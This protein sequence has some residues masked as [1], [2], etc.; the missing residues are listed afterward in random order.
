[1]ES[2]YTLTW[3]E[4][5]ELFTDSWPRP[6]YFSAA[7]VALVSIPLIAYGIIL[8]V[9]GMPDEHTI[10]FIFIG[11]PV[12]LVVAAFLSLASGNRKA[13]KQAM[14]EKRATYERWHAKEQ[15]FAFD[16]EKWILQSESGKLEV[17]WSALLAAVEWPSVLVLASEGAA[18]IVPKRAMNEGKLDLLRKMA[19]LEP[20]KKWPFKISVWD[21]QA[22]ET[23]R[24]W[25]RYWFRMAFGNVFGLVVLGWLFQIWHESNEKIG[26]VWGW[27]IAA[28]MLV[29]T[30]TAQIWY[31]PLKYWTSRREWRA[32]KELGLCGK[33]LYIG[34]AHVRVFNAW[35][36]LQSFDDFRRAF[37]VYKD[38]N[39]YHL[40]SK[41]YFFQEQREEI[42]RGLQENMKPK[43]T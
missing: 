16:E 38:K 30:L 17:P 35:K 33:G 3:E 4:Y 20:A 18:A 12:F 31:L 14:A 26:I 32:Q 43:S 24:I 42:R 9:F 10:N 37:V 23:V 41:H 40:L 27:V 15:S 7:V 1:M 28:F 19:I 22:T 5:A 8:A 11:G 36:Y 2:T 13:K 25:K 34:D 6:D 21:Y 39:H 29:L